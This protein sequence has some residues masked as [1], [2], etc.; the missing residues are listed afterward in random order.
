MGCVNAGRGAAAAAPAALVPEPADSGDAPP[1]VWRAKAGRRFTGRMVVTGETIYGG[2]VDR[3]VYAVDLTSGQLLWSSRLGGLISGGV[4]VAGDT[5]Y[6]ASSRPEGRVYAL[7]G[8]TGRRLWRTATG[9]VGAPLAL[10]GGVL[11]A[12]TQ[13]GEVLGLDPKA[14]T[15]RWRRKVGVS[16]IPAVEADSGTI[17]IATVDSLFRLS[18]KD[19]KVV[20][21]ALSPGAIVSPWIA[22]RGKLVAGTTD[23]LVVAIDPA[24]LRPRWRVTLDA[25]VLDSPAAGGDTLY[26]A[27][28]RGT[29]YRIVADSEPVAEA[30]AELDWPITAPVTVLDGL[31]FLGGA[32]GVL[33]A[34]RPDGSEAWR[35][36]LRWPVELGPL[37][38]ADGLLAVGGDGDIHRYRR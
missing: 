17:V 35:L 10:M 30:I 3:K 20:R 1:Q 5:V 11:V 28:R 33:R 21:R 7:D 26:A 31:V 6:A 38:L 36:S 29:L 34:L 14:G 25:P 32:D 15:V 2:S 4:L 19:G 9:P 37:P 22:H 27:T 12:E 23:S 18:S 24:D 13:R 8:K 16:R